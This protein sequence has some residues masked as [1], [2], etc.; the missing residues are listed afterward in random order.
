EGEV[1]PDRAGGRSVVVALTDSPL[2]PEPDAPALAAAREAGGALLPCR[3]LCAEARA[4]EGGLSIAARDL[5][6][7]AESRTARGGTAVFPGARGAARVA[8][9]RVRLGARGDRGLGGAGGG[10]RDRGRLG[11][12]EFQDDPGWAGDP[13]GAEDPGAVRARFLRDGDRIAC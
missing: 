9:R 10:E 12:P 4:P 7:A 8:G 2:P 6:G 5:R 13:D 3:G 11:R 1:R